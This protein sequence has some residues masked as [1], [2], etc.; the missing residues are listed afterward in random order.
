[1]ATRKPRGT[2][3]SA[4]LKEKLEA[5]KKRLADLE[6]RA[7]A[8]ELSE[9]ISSTNIVA[10]FAKIQARVTDIK[11]VAILAAI[12]TAIGIKRLE[13]K[14]LEAPKRKPA[15]PNKPRKQREKKT[16]GK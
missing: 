4:E 15:D 8:E 11:D 7:Y 6:K 14:Q 2:T 12:G 3:T 1:M 13:V 10:D 9:L 16:T 5:A